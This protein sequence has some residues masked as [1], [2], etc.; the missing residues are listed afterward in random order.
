MLVHVCIRAIGECAEGYI[1]T[2]KALCHLYAMHSEAIVV[3][4]VYGVGDSVGNARLMISSSQ[5][6]TNEVNES[7]LYSRNGFPLMSDF[8]GSA[9]CLS[10]IRTEMIVKPFN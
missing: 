2:C 10:S 3:D 1:R 6:M 5:L 7:Q 9:A 8:Y 4:W